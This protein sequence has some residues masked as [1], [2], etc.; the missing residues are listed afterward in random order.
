MTRTVQNLADMTSRV[1]LVVGG[2]GHVGG[3]AAQALMELGASVVIM[4]LDQER[5]TQRAA[6]LSRETGRPAVGI[7]CDL[8]DEDATRAGVRAAITTW[9]RL[10][11]VVHCAAYV[12]T[13]KVPGWVAPFAEQ[14]VAAWDAA[15][16]VS[17]TSAFVIA[18]ETAAPLAASGH[19]VMVLVGSTYG[20]VGPDMRLYTDTPMGNPAGYGAAK[21]GLLQLGRYL[22]TTLAPA[23][24]VNLVSP[25]GIERGQPAVFQER[26][27][28]RTPLGRMATEE[29]LKG[30]IVYLASDLSAYVTGQNLIVD[31][32]WT[33]W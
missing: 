18:Q 21:G 5:C 30:A 10:D 2:A 33:T 1:A 17:L 3:A 6:E 12:G 4:D 13:T 16:R 20:I 19:G 26:Y 22:A 14:T 23:V 31:G 27:V 11:A 28:S 25:G 9:G 15:L 29:D 24:R 32:G 7:A 8:G